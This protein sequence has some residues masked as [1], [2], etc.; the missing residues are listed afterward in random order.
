MVTSSTTA[1]I[2]LVRGFSAVADVGLST[3]SRLEATKANSLRVEGLRIYLL[4]PE[5]SSRAAKQPIQHCES[6]LRTVTMKILSELSIRCAEPITRW[7][8]LSQE[9]TIGTCVHEI[10]YCSH[11]QVERGNPR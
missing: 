1:A 5:N 9:P 11:S 6:I 2:L 3:I 7:K 10:S 8:G 4:Q